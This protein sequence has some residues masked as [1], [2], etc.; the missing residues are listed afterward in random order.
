MS[1]DALRWR[2]TKG[3]DGSLKWEGVK[4]YN[5]DE[6]FRKF[7]PEQNGIRYGQATP[8]HKDVALTSD[9]NA[10]LSDVNDHISKYIQDW[11]IRCAGE[12]G[13]DL[14]QIGAETNS[15]DMFST[16]KHDF[17]KAE[18]DSRETYLNSN[19]QLLAEKDQA[20][21]D[22]N[23]FR[24]THKGRPNIASYPD[25]NVLHFGIVFLC[26]VAEGIA[27]AYFFSDN[28]LGLIGG[29]LEALLISL[30]NV[31]ASFMAGWLCLREINHKSTVRKA[32]GLIGFMVIV[33]FLVFLHLAS[34]QY[35]E[36]LQR[37]GDV[38]FFTSLAF[39]PSTLQ[40]MQSF[41]LMGIGAVISLFAM[42]KGYTF[43]DPYPGYGKVY[44]IWKDRNDK[45]SEAQLNYTREVNAAYNV[46]VQAVDAISAK[47]DSKMG[48]LKDFEAE[49]STYFA[50]VDSYYSQAQG[51]ASALITAFRGGVETSWG[52][53]GTF[54]VPL[55]LLNSKL[56]PID[57]SQLKNDVKARLN[58][59]LDAI[60]ASREYY[61]EKREDMIQQLEAEREA[62]IGKMEDTVQSL[63][64]QIKLEKEQD[65]KEQ[66]KVEHSSTSLTDSLLISDAVESR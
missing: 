45:V 8:Q 35:R 5:K 59:L 29:F 53:S 2:S 26:L 48:S 40:D 11:H 65:Q 30:A 56:Q 21:R 14:N 52:T 27:N 4:P 47:L 43:D 32:L 13:K 9:E 42:Y 41:L 49:M 64:E 39:N 36:A 46:A 44:R 60:L 62:R 24:G 55:D 58:Q 15:R 19:K 12:I 33:V 57:P 28:S 16:I 20:R 17:G 18:L 50:C 63:I 34:A 23:A 38:E 10:M 66:D 1:D 54:P 25:S 37:S 22:L 31:V 6:A 61:A 3:K 51:A 7:A